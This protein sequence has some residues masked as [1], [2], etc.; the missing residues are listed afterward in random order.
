MH[1]V[2]EPRAL[3][4]CIH[5]VAQEYLQDAYEAGVTGEIAVDSLY[6][7]FLEE[8][9]LVEVSQEQQGTLYSRAG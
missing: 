7:T 1:R 2:I 6:R 4:S 3:F 5:A 9:E 8:M